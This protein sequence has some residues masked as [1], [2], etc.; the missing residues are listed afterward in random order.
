[1][2]LIITNEI[3]TNAG[4]TTA[5]YININRFDINKDAMVFI[6]TNLY[7]NKDARE[8]NVGD[9]VN[10][11]QVAPILRL[12]YLDIREQLKTLTIHEILYSKLKESLESQGHTVVDDTI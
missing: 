9:T 3:Y 10:T 1:M 2:G 6:A 12:D 7:L 5:L 4:V 8:L 11:R